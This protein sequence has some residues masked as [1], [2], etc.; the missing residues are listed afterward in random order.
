MEVMEVM[1]GATPKGLEE[2]GVGETPLLEMVLPGV[3]AIPGAG[4]EPGSQEEE[5]EGSRLSNRAQSKPEG[6]IIIDH[7]S[8]I[9]SGCADFNTFYT[10]FRG[11]LSTNAT[12]C[13]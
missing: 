4:D 11:I 12:V 8:R 3:T 2:A 10:G 7:I 9:Q 6:T 13:L 5:G 1:E